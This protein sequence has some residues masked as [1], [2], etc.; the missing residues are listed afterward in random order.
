MRSSR[1]LQEQAD[2]ADGKHRNDHAGEEREDGKR[3]P[4]EPVMMQHNDY[5]RGLFN[6]DQGLILRVSEAGAP[7]HFMAVFPRRDGYSVFHLDS[8]RADIRLSFAITVHKGQG[9]EFDHVA[10]VLPD[11][12]VPILT[13]ELLYT[14]VT[15]SRRSVVIVGD[16][17][18][19]R[20]GTEARLLRYSGIAERLAAAD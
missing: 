16:E 6:G 15:R 18:V 2:A 1:H 8:L 19:L 14:A 5:D 9:S 11:E 3:D 4:G 10:I 17:A 13:R 7:H 12:P 20:A